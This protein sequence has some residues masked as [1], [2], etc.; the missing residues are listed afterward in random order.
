VRKHCEIC[1]GVREF[2]TSGLCTGCG[3][4]H[5]DRPEEVKTRYTVVD[6]DCR[7]CTSKSATRNS[8]GQVVCMGCGEL[9][10]RPQPK[11]VVMGDGVWLF[12]YQR[13]GQE[14]SACLRV[15][16][17]WIIDVPEELAEWKNKP[18]KAIVAKMRAEFRRVQ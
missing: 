9:Q 11:P 12:R 18:A 1:R 10:G 3:S 14:R 16:G 4:P 7:R 8:M 6:V 17:G 2:T 5:I 15:Q 13:D